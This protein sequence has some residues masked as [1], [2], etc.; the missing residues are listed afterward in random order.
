VTGTSPLLLDQA[1]TVLYLLDGTVAASGTH[2][3]LLATAPGYR[4][5]VSR[6][7]EDPAPERAGDPEPTATTPSRR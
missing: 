5:L 2:R 6:D 7:A 1:D 3:D 4:A